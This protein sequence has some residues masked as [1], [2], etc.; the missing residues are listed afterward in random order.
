[1]E[2]VRYEVTKTPVTALRFIDPQFIEDQWMGGGNVQSILA[3]P[4]LVAGV[5]VRDDSDEVVIAGLWHPYDESYETVLCVPK[6][7]VLDRVD[8]Q[9]A[10]LLA[11][12]PLLAVVWWR[13]AHRHAASVGHVYARDIH[14]RWDCISAG[15]VVQDDDDCVAIGQWFNPQNQTFKQI[16]VI[17]KAAISDT[18]ILNPE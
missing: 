13:D 7:L 2:D 11:A 4:F 3:P 15:F 12:C 14:S 5:F 9:G 17:P 8:N 6:S 18:T 10:Q 16:Y 1:M